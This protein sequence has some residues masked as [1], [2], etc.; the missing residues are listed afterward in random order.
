[1]FGRGVLLIAML[2][3]S[4]AVPYLIFNGDVL[5][6]G[7]H[8]WRSILGKDGTAD[9]DPADFP[10]DAGGEN[11]LYSSPNMAALVP[12]GGT[13]KPKGPQLEG[14]PIQHLSQLFRFDINPSWITSNWS[15]VT[16]DLSDLSLNGMR[17]MVVTGTQ[18]HDLS[19]SL[20]YYYD[21]P[22]Q[23]QRVTFHGHTG[24]PSQLIGFVTQYYFMQPEVTFGE[25][26]Y[27]AKWNSKPYSGLRL[28]RASVGKA[29]SPYE[30]MEIDLELNRPESPYGFSPAFYRL[31]EQD[32][33]AR[34]W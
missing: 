13:D 31:L 21:K 15:R 11:G 27:L 24:D 9:R 14:P 1:M 20:T 16:T 34:R 30:Q 2:G 12:G 6:K 3:A 5:N 32:V 28:R 22:R 8:W 18:L 10:F 4:V 33:K 29:A 26:L 23:L 7:S 19:G 17:V 25:G